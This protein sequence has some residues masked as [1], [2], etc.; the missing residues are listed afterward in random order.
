VQTSPLQIPVRRTTGPARP[1][2]LIIGSGFGGLAAAVRLLVRGYDVTILERGDQP[3]G[4]ARVHRMDGHVFDAGPTVITAPFLLEELWELAGR[5][6]ADD[7]ELLPVTPFYRVRFD[8]GTL[9]D[10]SG[11][12][13]R[14]EDEVA[15]IAP[16][17]VEGYRAF[18]AESRRIFE[19]GFERLAHRPFGRWQ[20]MAKIVPDMIRLGSHRTVHGLVA[21]HVRSEKLRQVLSFHP[22][23]VG[24]N[25]F[26]TTSIYA[27][28]AYLERRWGVWFPRGGTGALVRALAQLIDDLGGVLRLGAEVAQVLVEGGRAT[29]VCLANGELIRADIVVSNADPAHTYRHM[30]APEHRRHW[31]DRRVERADYSMG[32]FVWYFGTSRRYEDVAHHTILMGP[33]YRELLRDIFERKVL[34]DDFSLYLHRPTL[35]DPGLAPP[36]RDTFYV[37]AP[38]PHLDATVDWTEAAEPYRRRIE[39]FL[40]ATLLPDLGRNVTASRLLTPL[41]FRDGLLSYKGAAFGMQPTLRQSAYFRPHNES[42]DVRGLYF[43]GAGTHPGAGVPGVLSSARVLDELVPPAVQLARRCAHGG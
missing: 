20:D 34:A 16:G 21:R 14:M 39:A 38:V 30:I 32:L 33:R 24:G 5:R 17:E 10:Y 40:G 12:A 31:S 18:V 9:F 42:E 2:A 19:V 4:R 35:T 3:G 43:V 26:T 15:R 28:I 8:D 37:L 11:D 1:R 7:V 22:L 27:L 6:L 41:D 23:L 13:L 36:G 29:G 25:P